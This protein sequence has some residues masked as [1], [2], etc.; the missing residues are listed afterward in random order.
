M[1]N[2]MNIF[3]LCRDV[4]LCAQ[5]LC[6]RHV[7]KMILE[8]AQILCTAHYVLDKEIVGYKPTHVNHPSTKWC[9]E[10]LGNYMW[11]Y[12]MF[13]ATLNEYTYRYG[14]VHKSS[15][16]VEVLQTPPDNIP[17][18][19]FEEPPQAMPEEYKSVRGSIDAY[20]N[21]YAYGKAHLHAWKRRPTPQF[22]P[23]TLLVQECE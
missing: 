11:L 3:Y 13:I 16:L 22:I 21:Y 1:K 5:M 12:N 10:G 4:H 14:K 7:V 18:R 20:R 19:A 15:E 2:V 6:D 8:Y 17:L 23:V 9:R